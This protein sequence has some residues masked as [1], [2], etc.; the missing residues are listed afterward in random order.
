MGTFRLK[1]KQKEFV[2]QL[3]GLASGAMNFLG[4]ASTPLMVGQ[5]Y[6]ESQNA[7]AQERQSE[8]Q[9]RLM[10]QQNKALNDIAEAAKENPIAAQQAAQVMQK[11]YSK[12]EKNFSVLKNVGQFG[13]DIWKTWG[14]NKEGGWVKDGLKFGAAGGLISYGA[15][16]WIQHDMKKEGIQMPNTPQQSN[17]SESILSKNAAAA[18]DSGALKVLGKVGTGAMYGMEGG[19]SLL[20]YYSQKK[21][22]KAQSLQ[23]QQKTYSVLN[24][25]G[26]KIVSGAKSLGRGAKG[27][28]YNFGLGDPGKIKSIGQ[29]WQNSNS[30]ISR[31]VGKFMVNHSKAAAL[32]GIPIGFGAMGFAFEKTGELMKKPIEAVDKNAF[33]WDKSQEQKIE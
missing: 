29:T 9:A 25:V 3:A 24:T 21:Q 28:V 11:S 31:N 17:Y 4:A 2:V 18:T 27:L 5:M 32:A 13:K 6:Q 20:G 26:S 19:M 10:K 30:S 15:N 1:R 23:S 22:L 8:E 33:A 7:E 14:W 12:S 16:K